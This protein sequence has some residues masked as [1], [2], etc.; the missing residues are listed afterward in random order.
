M[1]AKLRFLSTAFLLLILGLILPTRLAFAAVV[2]NVVGQAQATAITNITTAGLTYGGNIQQSSVSVPAGAVISQNPAAGINVPVLTPVSLVVSSGAAPPTNIATPNVVGQNQGAAGT[3]ITTAGLIVGAVSLQVNA[4]PAGTVISQSPAPG[5]LLGPGSPVNLVVSSGPGQVAVP[6][7]RG[8]LQSTATTTLQNAGLNVTVSN[9]AQAACLPAVAPVTCIPGTVSALNPA[10]GTWVDPG[11]FINISVI[12]PTG[13]VSAPNVIGL[14]QNIAINTIQDGGLAVGGVTYEANATVPAGNVISQSVPPGVLI[15]PN[16][17][18]PPLYSPSISIVVS[19]G[20]NSPADIPVPDVVNQ[21]QSAAIATI[22]TAGFTIGAVTQQFSA[23]IPAGTVISQSPL[24]GVLAAPGAAVDLVVSSGT[25]QPTTVPVPDVVGQPQNTAIAIIQGIGLTIGTITQQTSATVLAG[26][27]ISQSPVANIGVALGS[28]VDIVVSSGTAPPTNVLVPSLVGLFQND[29]ITAIQ[30]A[31]LTVGAI[32]QAASATVP[33]GQVISQSPVANISVALGSPVSFVV[34][35]GTVPPTTVP[36]PNV[37]GLTQNAAITAIQ[38]AALTVGAITQATSA[39]V[40]AGTVISQNPVDGIN[41]VLGTP[42]SFVVSSGTAP[43]TNIPVPDVVGQPQNTAIAAI[44]AVALTVGAITPQ[45]SATVP[46]GTVIS[47]SPAAGINV[48]LGS[49]VNIVVSSGPGQVAVPNVVSLTQ[50]AAITAIQG[51]GLTIGTITQATS[52]TVAAGSVISQS[53]VA[54]ISVALGSPVDFVVS[55]GTAPPTNVLVPNVV[56]LTQA[57][58]ITAIQG[59]ALTVGTITQATSATVPAGSVISQNPA[60]G[61]NVAIGSPVSFVV[62]TGASLPTN[63]LVPNVVGQTQAA[64]IAAIQSVGLT[65]TV[66]TA[67]SFTVPAGAVISQSPVGG[68]SVALGSPVAI[69]VST[70]SVATI[71]VPNVVNLTQAAAIAAIQDAGLTVGAITQAVSATVPKGAVIS[72]TPVAGIK[73]AP[74]SAVDIV[75]SS[76]TTPP[77]TV[78][79]PNVVGQ[80]QSAAIAAIQSVGLTVTVTR[81]VSVTI[82]VDTVISQNPVGGVSVAL[83]SAV[84]IV[85]SGYDEPGVVPNVVGQPQAAAKAAIEAAGFKV[86]SVTLA[87]SNTPAGLVISQ[88]PAGG[89]QVAPGSTVNLTVSSGAAPPPAPVGNIDVPDVIGLNKTAASSVIRSAGLSVGATTQ[90]HDDTAPAGNVIDQSPAAGTKVFAGALVNIT[91][92][93]GP[94]GVT[95][96]PDVRGQPEAVAKSNL[97]NAGFVIGQTLTEPDPAMPLG[98]VIRT[99]PAAG[100]VAD[101]GAS[102]DLIV[103]A[104]FSQPQEVTV[105]N[106]TNQTVENARE[107]LF[108][109]CLC[110]IGSITVK[111]DPV[112]PAGLV[113]GQVPAANA[114]IGY[115]TTVNLFVSSGSQ[116]PVKNPNV[117]G[118]SLADASATLV[119]ARLK[120][121]FVSRQTSNTVKEGLVI[122][123]NPLMTALIPVGWSVNLVVSLGPIPE[124]P[125]ARPQT[126]VPAVINK[127]LAAATADLINAGLRVGFVANQRS[128]TVPVGQVIRQSPQPDATVPVSS[129]V[130][131]VIS[132]GPYGYGLLSGPAYITNYAGNTVSIINPEINGVVDNLPTGISANGPSGIAV[133]P[134]GTKLYVA[135]RPQYGRRAGSLS[136]IDLAERKVIAII[137]VGVAPLG[138]AIN[139][140]GERVFVANEGSSSLSVINTL[141]NQPFIDLSV[142][143]LGAN[144]FPRGVAAHPNPLQ[145]LVYVTNRTVNSYSDDAQNPY[146]DQCDALV[147]RPPVNVNPDQCVGSLSILDIDLKTQ[148]GSV[149]VGLAPEG[150]AVHPDGM[151]VY[152]ANSGDRTVSVIETVFNRVIGVI[153][154]DEFG[155]APQPLIPRGVAV[156]PD[157]N[158]LYVTDGGGNRLFVIDTTANHAIV[159]IVPVGK[160]PYGVAVSP[161]SQRVYVANQNDNTVSIVDGRSNAVIATIPTG[162]EPWAF[163]QFVGPLATVAPPTFNPPGSGTVYALG[164]TVTISSSTPGASIRYTQDGSTPTATTG[165]LISNGQAVALTPSATTD[166]V[167]LKAVAFKD[168]WADSE[169]TEAT[170]TLNR[171]PFGGGF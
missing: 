62:S 84:A 169:V 21:T 27:V 6:D 102:I 51:A 151:L 56:N 12:S 41:V 108:A 146:P 163:G 14:P 28:P 66:T 78:L 166:K 126:Q 122:S 81:Q 52:A 112:I 123:Q 119:N 157:G 120:V 124:D 133:H 92:S 75:V 171:L 2:P 29:A 165:T 5:A 87:V 117:V 17:S 137:P 129:R 100:T 46:A 8:N 90:K 3:A 115:N 57:A 168:G 143:N 50:A 104:G 116:A 79:V 130:N 107:I 106:V 47:Q 135:N 11:T 142:P 98:N 159:S 61:I 30:G 15:F 32:T 139:S 160:K 73:V 145:P 18:P 141:T 82:P 101:T 93:L 13:A 76:G 44:Q 10:V 37:V 88:S 9:Q 58:A 43:P 55:S 140:T 25:S 48:A 20:P 136:V 134:D 132:F 35:S 144:P 83:G 85:V 110:G 158:R 114:L 99:I 71:T 150:V 23:T 31:A 111:S 155:G 89:S 63:V 147:A 64:A 22:Q 128:E 167:V 149:A 45:A 65:V 154:L 127:T 148:V 49:P 156:S 118:M 24:A 53:P 125:G 170:Y 109:T 162:L 77:N 33:A 69:V 42:V 7:V 91:V 68:I 72:Q 39:T 67:A 36:V 94:A 95:T 60:A 113:S 19:T 80:T 131:L 38:T 105:P 103:S 74:G 161:D 86:G 97:Q 121:G 40:P 138:V 16:A 1:Q 54:G 153:T 34:S 70:G 59:V 96:V 26:R 164:V 4:A 152:V